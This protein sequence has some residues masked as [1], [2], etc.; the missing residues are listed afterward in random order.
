MFCGGN[1]L[2]RYGRKIKEATGNRIIRM[3][4]KSM[5]R[6]LSEKRFK[7]VVREEIK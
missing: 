4:G 2:R 5:R 6:S 1:E 3:S 7:R